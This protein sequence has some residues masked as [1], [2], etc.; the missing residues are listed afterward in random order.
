[1]VLFHDLIRQV[2]AGTTGQLP[3]SYSNLLLVANS[4]GSVVANHLLA[5]FPTDFDQVALTGFSGQVQNSFAGFQLTVPQPAAVVDPPR[6]GAFNLG[7]LAS[8]SETGN[9]NTY[10]GSLAQVLFDPAVAQAFFQRQDAYAMGQLVSLYQ[11]TT[12][13][14]RF[15]GRVLVLNGAADQ[16]FCGPGSPVIGA[17]GCGTA[18]R[19]SAAQLFPSAD[20]NYAS[21]DAAGNAGQLHFS[22]EA[23]AT[24]IV[25]FFAGQSFA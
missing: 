13:A 9:T 7:Y 1:M 11:G 17:A 20:F 19:D 18:Q 10:F 16:L 12:T 23:A 24:K 4:Y 15:L 5:D 3:R 22:T 8:S 21:Q 14:Q 25:N 6:F 2:R